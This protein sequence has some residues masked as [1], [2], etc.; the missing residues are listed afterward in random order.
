MGPNLEDLLLLMGQNEKIRFDVRNKLLKG[1]TGVL[2]HLVRVLK[3]NPNSVIRRNAALILGE[4]GSQKAVDAL[5]GALD[6]RAATVS[7][8]AA[9][10]LGMIGDKRAVA[11]LIGRLRANAW[12]VR[13]N[14]AISLGWLADDGASDSLLSLLRDHHAYVRRGAA[15]ALGQIGKPGMRATLL[16][17][18]TNKETPIYEAAVVLANMGDLSGYFYLDSPIPPPFEGRLPKRSGKKVVGALKLGNLFYTSSLYPA[19]IAEYRRAMAIEEKNLAST[20]TAVLN[21]IGNAFR[22]VGQPD[23]AIVFYLLGLRIKPRDI[24]LRNNLRKAETLSDIQEHLLER[25]KSWGK[26]H[27]ALSPPPDFIRYFRTISEGLPTDLLDR[28]LP[29]FILGWKGFYALEAYRG[30]QGHPFDFALPL[31][32]LADH[33][34]VCRSILMREPS[35]RSFYHLL[36]KLSHGQMTARDAD[37]GEEIVTFFHETFLCGY[38]V[39]LLQKIWCMSHLRFSMN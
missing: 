11:P 38:I 35:F 2:E 32:F 29:H 37:R 18:L 12:Q 13:L 39:G 22:L 3:S 26:E 33:V 34:P 4:L 6:D 14:A 5:I 25:V 7:S 30:E 36:L 31:E 21:N 20:Y 23:H 28:F 8:N 19:A 1:G 9:I 10:A 27:P 15:F 24:E 17:L 16:K